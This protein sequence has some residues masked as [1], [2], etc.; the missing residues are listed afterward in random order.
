MGKV[1][2]MRPRPPDGQEGWKE[3]GEDRAG[4]KGSWADSG[5]GRAPSPGSMA[6]YKGTPRDYQVRTNHMSALLVCHIH[7]E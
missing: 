4:S 2:R 6:Q 7:L 1:E 3:G 5:D